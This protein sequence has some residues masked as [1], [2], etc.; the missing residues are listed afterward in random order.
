MKLTS[1]LSWPWVKVK[2]GCSPP[3]ITRKWSRKCN[4]GIILTKEFTAY[5]RWASKYVFTWRSEEIIEVGKLKVIAILAIVYCII[6][7]TYSVGNYCRKLFRQI[8]DLW[9]QIKVANQKQ[10]AERETLIRSTNDKNHKHHKK[11]RRNSASIRHSRFNNFKNINIGTLKKYFL[12]MLFLDSAIKRSFI[13]YILSFAV[14]MSLY[15][16]KFPPNNFV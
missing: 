10:K 3:K 14:A 12:D 7:I 2:D 11:S 9:S 16:F 13:L 5:I 1:T 8:S 6:S 15:K 4:I